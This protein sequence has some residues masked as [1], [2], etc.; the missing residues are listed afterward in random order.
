MHYSSISHEETQNR[1]ADDNK[2]FKCLYPGCDR[3]YRMSRSQRYHMVTLHGMTLEEVKQLE[4]K[5]QKVYT[6]YAPLFTF[7][8]PIPLQHECT[9]NP[10]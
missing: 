6:S 5:T 1:H 9:M 7:N 2:P 8:T 4:S 3:T 10:Q